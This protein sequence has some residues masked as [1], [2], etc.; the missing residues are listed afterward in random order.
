[1]KA[2]LIYRCTACLTRRLSSRLCRK[3]SLL[4][5]LVVALVVL[6][7][8]V[9]A[10]VVPTALVVPEKSDD[11]GDSYLLYSDFEIK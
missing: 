8:L 3:K 1:M 11:F 7:A 10:L 5:S 6:T 9:V 2:R 4:D